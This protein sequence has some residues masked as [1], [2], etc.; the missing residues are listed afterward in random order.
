MYDSEIPS[1]E[2]LEKHVRVSHT[3]EKAFRCRLQDCSFQSNHLNELLKHMDVHD[4]VEKQQSKASNLHH[5]NKHSSGNGESQ[6]LSKQFSTSS[7]CSFIS[8]HPSRKTAYARVCKTPARYPPTKRPKTEKD[9]INR[10]NS[11]LELEYMKTNSPRFALGLKNVMTKI[12]S[13]VDFDPNRSTDSINVN[14]KVIGRRTFVKMGTNLEQI[15]KTEVLVRWFPLEICP[16]EWKTEDTELTLIKQVPISNV[17][18]KFWTETA[19]WLMRNNKKERL[20]K[21][22]RKSVP[23]KLNGVTV[24]TLW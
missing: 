24:A 20:A 8:N 2:R 3:K 18:K 12:K 5:D 7:N 15:E 1:F 21:S 13:F 11:L 16:D 10:T 17:P 4:K 14:G 6:I 19:S 22:K 9:E 23:S